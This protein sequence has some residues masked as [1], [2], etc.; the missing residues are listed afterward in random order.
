[1]LHMFVFDRYKLLLEDLLEHTPRDHHDYAQLQGKWYKLEFFF[2]V[3]GEKV[4]GELEA[5]IFSELLV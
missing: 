4:L 1:M 5:E 2:L 3:P